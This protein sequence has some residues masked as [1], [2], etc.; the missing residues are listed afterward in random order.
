[1]AQI[2]NPAVPNLP[3]G[4]VEY[5]K[6]FVDRHSNVLRLY[7]NQLNASLGLLFGARGGKYLSFPFIAASNTVDHTVAT[8][9][10][11]TLVTFDSEDFAS[12]GFVSPTDGFHVEQA[13]LYNY[14]F[15]IQFE[16]TDT[17]IHEAYVWLKV[18][19]SDFPWSGSQTSVP[20]SH[21]GVSGTIITTANFLVSL[22]AGDYVE[23]WWAAT[24]TQVTMSALAATTSPYVRPGSPSVVATLTFV[25]ALPA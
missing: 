20:N 14:Q 3:L 9:N 10:A 2:I 18:N 4:P 1:M 6:P 8:I 24:S 7:F 21:G 16:N 11:P 17:Q 15:S 12:G 25:S 5:Q 19:G 13:G 22:N 23:L